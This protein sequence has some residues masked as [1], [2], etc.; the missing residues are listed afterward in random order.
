MKQI[1]LVIGGFMGLM[2]FLIC[3][4]SIFTYPTMW[5]WNALIP[6]LFSGPVLNFWQTFGL[7]LLV[8]I[9]SSQLSINND[10]D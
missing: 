8:K 10:K 3:Y 6:D 7:M 1:G 4:I 5:L 2:V 9:L